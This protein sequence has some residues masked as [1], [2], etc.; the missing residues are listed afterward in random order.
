MKERREI[1]KTFNRGGEKFLIKMVPI[2]L[3]MNYGTDELDVKQHLMT[4]C[5]VVNENDVIKDIDFVD[6]G[7]LEV[8]TKTFYGA[9]LILVLVMTT[10]CLADYNANCIVRPLVKCN[11]RL[12]TVR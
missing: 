1:I 4:L 3:K 8:L 6:I 9:L 7:V 10:I 5:F 11:S 2:A 12:G